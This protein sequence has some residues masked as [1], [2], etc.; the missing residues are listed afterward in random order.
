M[1]NCR[2]SARREQNRTPRDRTVTPDDAQCATL[3]QFP[4]RARTIVIEIGDLTG[5]RVKFHPH[6]DVKR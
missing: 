5:R 1:V 6:P 3:P 4:A 2:Q